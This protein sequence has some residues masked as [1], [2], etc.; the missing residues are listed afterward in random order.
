MS[1]SSQFSW[2]YEQSRLAG[3][4]KMIAGGRALSICSQLTCQSP[5]PWRVQK[6]TL[7]VRKAPRLD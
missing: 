4:V 6:G 2:G 7:D 1:G 3:G 5:R